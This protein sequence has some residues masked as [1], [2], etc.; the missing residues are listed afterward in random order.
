MVEDLQDP[1]AQAKRSSRYIGYKQTVRA[2]SEGGVEYVLMAHDIDDG[3][4]ENL[5]RLCLMRNVPLLKTVSKARLGAEM[6]IEVPCA[7][8]AVLK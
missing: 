2:L 8:V 5:S 4:A 6:Q 3:M 7:V 1:L